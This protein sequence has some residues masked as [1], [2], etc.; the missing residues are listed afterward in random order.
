MDAK[1]VSTANIKL[2][3]P[4]FMVSNMEQSLRFYVDGLDFVVTNQWTPSGKTEWCWLQRD[5][6]SF[7]LQQSREDIRQDGKPGSGVSICFQCQDALALYYE[8]VSKGLKVREPFVGN[9]MWV[10][11]IEDPDGYKL[12]FESS[13]DVPEETTYT[14]YE[15]QRLKML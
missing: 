5:G 6:V 4:F 1:K 12:D 9:N 7:M 8:V 14:E 3:V 10:V 13:T 2:A 15:K 11:I